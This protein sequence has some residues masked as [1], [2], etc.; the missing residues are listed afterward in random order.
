MR[1]ARLRWRRGDRGAR[2]AAG[3]HA[4]AAPP[5]THQR[6][7]PARKS[8][9]VRHDHAVGHQG[10]RDRQRRRSSPRP[11]STSAWR[12][13]R[14]PTAARFRPRRSTRLRQQVLRNLIDETLQIQ[15]AKTEKIDD[16]AV[17]HRPDRRAGRREREADPRPARANSSRPTARRSDVAAPPDRRRNRVAAA[18]AAPRSKAASASATTRSRRC[19]DKL[20]ASKGTEEYHV[21]EIFLSATARQP[22]AD[23]GQRRQDPRAAEERRLLRR[24]C[25]AIFRGL[26]RGGRRRPR[27]GPPRAASARRSPL[28]SRQMAPGTVSNP[29]AVPGGVSIIAVQD[30]RKVLTRRPA[31]R[32]A[33]PQAGLDQLPQGHHAPAGRADR[34]AIR[35]GRAQRRR[36][37]RSREDR[38]RLPRRGRP[39]RRGQDARPAAGASAD[40]AADAGRPGDPAVRL[41]RGRRSRA[42]DLRPR[43]GRARASRP[44]TRSTTSSTKSG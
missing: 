41:A 39:E 16:Q 5:S 13:W 44:T 37:R 15:A 24:L 27:L 12:C 30:T 25:A 11:T 17:R 23:H 4:Q 38:R 2:P 28:R 29:I 7:A 9:G 8:A 22:G 32:G 34:R 18:A 20:N 33:E 26:D 42:G 21:G 36:L 35:R 14:S 43:R 1:R 6:A 10:D 19:I 3:R 31:R 40:D